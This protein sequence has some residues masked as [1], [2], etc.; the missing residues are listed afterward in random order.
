MAQSESPTKD[1]SATSSTVTPETASVQSFETSE[2]IGEVWYRPPV[3]T[4]PPR[5]RPQTSR[6]GSQSQ[7][8]ESPFSPTADSKSRNVPVKRNTTPL[9]NGHRTE[10]PG[11]ESSSTIK[12]KKSIQVIA[13]E[14]K[15]SFD[16]AF[17]SWRGSSSGTE[18]KSSVVGKTM[19][20]LKRRAASDSDLDAFP[21]TVIKWVRGEL[22]GGDPSGIGVYVGLNI[23]TGEMMAVK[24]AEIPQLGKVNCGRSELLRRREAVR[25]LQR[26]GELLATLD[27][28]NI[29]QYLGYEETE[30]ICN[31][32]LGY[33]AGESLG[34]VIRNYGRINH[35]NTIFFVAQILDGLEYLHSKGI[36]HR[37]MKADSVLVEN[38]GVCR[39]TSFGCHERMPEEPEDII[40]DEH[41][42]PTYWLAPEVMRLRRKGNL[43]KADIWS[44][45]CLWLEMLTGLGPWSGVEMSEALRQ[46]TQGIPPSQLEEFSLSELAED[47][48]QGCFAIRPEER[49]TA[50]ELQ[51]HEYLHSAPDWQFGGFS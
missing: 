7:R 19:K 40:S 9:T 4:S 20:L 2:S 17:K 30:S 35:D 41:Q 31:L 34:A 37:D 48:R 43:F 28:S 24:Q 8:E 44:T 23:K 36:A 6:E 5:N 15:K 16:G 27:H 45:G 22:I 33:A 21:V 13:A 49:A 12:K 1:H 25:K 32:L 51:D 47:F 18:P 3:P 14:C 10:S 26:E 50:A 46:L 42:A 11:G 39:L 38:D 29:V